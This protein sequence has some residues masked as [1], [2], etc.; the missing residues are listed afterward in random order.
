MKRSSQ[1]N[2]NKKLIISLV[3]CLCEYLFSA[4]SYTIVDTSQIR[5]YNNTTEIQYPK[6]G[7][8]FFG[9][10]AQYN[11]NQPAYND[12]GDG[13]V[14]D[15]NTKLMWTQSPDKKKTFRQAII[16]ASKCKIGNYDDWRL[17]TIK[18]LYSLILFNGID[19]GPMSRD[20]SGQ[21]P[22]I[23][24][25]YYKFQ[26]GNTTKGDRLIDSQFAT[27]TIYRGTT[28]KGNKT[29]FGVNF[30]DGRIKGYPI[31]TN[32]PRGEKKYHVMYVRS[33]TDY[34][35]NDFKDNGDGTVTDNAT[36]LIWMKVD[37]GHF[38]VGRNGAMNWGQSLKWAE[39]LEYANHSDWRLPNAKELQSLVDYTRCP[40]VTNSAAI[41]PIFEVTTI[42]NEGGKKDY[43]YYWT[44][45]TH[46]SIA[47]ADAAIYFAFGRA[48]RSCRTGKQVPK[49]LWMSMATT[50]GNGRSLWLEGGLP[51]EIVIV[52]NKVEKA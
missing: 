11:S 25:R 1:M 18:E 38:K 43:P 27:A 34:G 30:A 41:D 13:T 23:D 31:D 42:K 3:L 44:S 6:F 51:T 7:Q 19:P 16:N 15:L 10:D 46:T 52:R 12:N 17:P 4:Q 2:L 36:G 40:D 50:K 48:W 24:T 49:N 39:N 8:S 5:C 33:N 20:T 29:M 9:Q 32:G 22:Y 35:N 45:T 37:S 14:T 21:K 47:R 26:Y 28:M